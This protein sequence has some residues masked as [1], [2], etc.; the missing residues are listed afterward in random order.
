MARGPRRPGRPALATLTVTLTVIV[1]GILAGSS[2]AG[3]N[4]SLGTTGLAGNGIVR[5]SQEAPSVAVVAWSA[6]VDGRVAIVVSNSTTQPVRVRKVVATATAS[7]GT[8]SAKASTRTVVP[9]VLQPGEQGLGEIRFRAN[10]VRFDD[11]LAF[12]VT[13]R[14]VRTTDPVPLASGGFALSPPGTGDVAQTLDLVVTNDTTRAID[15]RIALRVVC[16]NEAGVPT[17]AAAGAVKHA[18]LAPGATTPASVDFSLLCPVYVV[19][20]EG[21]PAR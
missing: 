21:R 2:A 9:R 19:G 14:P 15:G 1:G 10:R 5:V 11:T 3:A 4:E 12:D 16:L 7:S 6:P 20:A 17:T 8:R 18:K 13:T